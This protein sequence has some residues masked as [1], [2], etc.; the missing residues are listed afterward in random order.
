MS[1]VIAMK[2]LGAPVNAGSLRHAR[3]EFG[4][5]LTQ[6]AD[7]MGVSAATIEK[8][9]QGIHPSPKSSQIESKYQEY[10]VTSCDKAGKNLLFG[11]YPLRMARQLLDDIPIEILASEYGYKKSAWLKFEANARSIDDKILRKLEARMRSHF[12]EVC[13]NFSD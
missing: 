4:L 10:A 5:T 13:T 7:A 12:S 6:A 1:N 9:E 8:W 2:K 3:N 11:M